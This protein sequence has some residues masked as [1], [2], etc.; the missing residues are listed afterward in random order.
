MDGAADILALSE[1]ISGHQ[2]AYGEYAY[3]EQRQLAQLTPPTVGGAANAPEV[4]NASFRMSCM[5]AVT[6][7]IGQIKPADPRL[8]W[9]LDEVPSDD[10]DDDAYETRSRPKYVQRKAL[11][12]LT[13]M[14]L[15]VMLILSLSLSLVSSRSFEILY[16][17]N[18]T[19]EDVFL[20]LSDKD[21]SPAHCEAMAVR[22]E[23][24]NH[25]QDDIE[26][27]VKKQ[28]L[29]LQSSS[30]KL[31]LYLPHPVRHQDGHAKWDPKKQTLT[32]SLPIIRDE[33]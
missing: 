32:I 15:S 13:T 21:P 28:K 23:C 26:L 16:K 14:L 3:E 9:N 20:G 19:T 7:P 27:D 33:W 17:Q 6:R 4:S 30:L 10:A 18:V 22:I 25:R 12:M 11:S 5:D 8:I 24:P 1:L 29:L 2:E 31:S